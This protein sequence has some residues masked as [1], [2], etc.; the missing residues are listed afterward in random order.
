MV[1]APRGIRQTVAVASAWFIARRNKGPLEAVR[2][3]DKG[4]NGYFTRK[5]C[6]RR[7]LEG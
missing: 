3:T 5:Q 4:K 2:N 6:F 7:H 1:F